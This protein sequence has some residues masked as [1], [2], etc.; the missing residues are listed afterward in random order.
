M[1][2]NAQNMKIIYLLR[3]REKTAVLQHLFLQSVMLVASEAMKL[4]H[5]RQVLLPYKFQKC[6]I[7]S[8][9]FNLQLKNSYTPNKRA[10]I[11][12]ALK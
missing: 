6:A 2:Y 8:Y 11:L 4:E 9:C 12:L 7:S 5:E 1:Q 10:I 3:L